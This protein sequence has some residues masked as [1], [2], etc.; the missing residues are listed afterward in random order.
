MRT[1]VLLLVAGVAAFWAGTTQ[2]QTAVPPE[3]GQPIRRLGNPPVGED[4]PAQKLARV[5]Q[6]VVAAGVERPFTAPV[7]VTVKT[8]T[9]VTTMHVLE[10]AEVRQLGGKSFLVGTVMDLANQQQKLA[11]AEGLA[12]NMMWVPVDNIAEFVELKTWVPKP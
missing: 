8:T 5:L 4:R 2:S 10:K 3:G 1:T 12:G 7:Y 11:N 6:P 9:L